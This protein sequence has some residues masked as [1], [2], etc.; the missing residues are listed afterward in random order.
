[1]SFLLTADANP[2][3]ATWSTGVVADTATIALGAATTGAIAVGAAYDGLP[4]LVTTQGAAVDATA[5]AFAASWDGA[6]NLTIV[7]NANAT[8]AVTLAYA[9]LGTV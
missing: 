6:G 2:G 3:T 1:M 8:A 7:S 4:V 9:V 5:T